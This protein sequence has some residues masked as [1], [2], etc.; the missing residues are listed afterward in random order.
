MSENHVLSDSVEKTSLKCGACGSSFKKRQ[1]LKMHIQSVHE[2]KNLLNA[3]SVIL[4]FRRRA[5]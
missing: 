4:V 3:I 1:N 5:I 2:R